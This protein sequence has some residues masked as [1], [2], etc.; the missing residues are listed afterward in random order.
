VKD[1]QER[2]K[3]IAKMQKDVETVE[4]KLD[5]HKGDIDQVKRR[6]IEP[7]QELIARINKNFA[8]FF[9]CLKCAGEVDLDIPENPVST[10]QAKLSAINPMWNRYKSYIGFPC[11]ILYRKWETW[12]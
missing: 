2:K 6:W 8:Y 11:T 7:L 10:T 5:T 3:L 12:N 4:L 9:R 1:Y